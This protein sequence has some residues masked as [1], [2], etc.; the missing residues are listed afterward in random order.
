MCDARLSPTGTLGTS[1]GTVLGTILG[2]ICAAGNVARP[3]S[4]RRNRCLLS[5]PRRLTVSRLRSASIAF[6]RH[7]AEALA[8]PGRA[9]MAEVALLPRG[10]RPATL[11]CASGPLSAPGNFYQTPGLRRK[12][13][14]LTQ[15]RPRTVFGI[16]QLAVTLLD[17][18]FSAAS[19]CQGARGQVPTT[20]KSSMP[21]RSRWWGQI[22]L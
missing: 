15:P 18:P 4:A 12:R 1:V 13:S 6:A 16:S 5:P 2:P 11:V 7:A 20:R 3:P 8:G 17:T 14:H 21:I 19:S 10:L 22:Q 9:L